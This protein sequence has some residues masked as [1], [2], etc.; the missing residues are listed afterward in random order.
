MT[1]V[2][3]AAVLVATAGGRFRHQAD[4]LGTARSAG[5]WPGRVRCNQNPRSLAFDWIAAECGEFGS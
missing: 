5:P 4:G 2:A 3:N 1:L